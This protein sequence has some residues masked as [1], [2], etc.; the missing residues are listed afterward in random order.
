MRNLHMTQ[1]L[2]CF[3]VGAPEPNRDAARDRVRQD[4][5]MLHYATLTPDATVPPPDGNSIWLRNMDVRRQ[6]N[7]DRL[8]V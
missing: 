3:R 8:A 5:Q 6:P 1:E 4:D 7:A 2:D